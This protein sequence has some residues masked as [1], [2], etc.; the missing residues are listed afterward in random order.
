MGISVS[1]EKLFVS[2]TKTEVRTSADEISLLS[3]NGAKMYM[4][5]GKINNAHG[6]VLQGNDHNAAH[7]KHSNVFVRG[8]AFHGMHFILA[9]CL[10]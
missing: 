5:G 3:H 2:L 4:K 10:E 7:I 1:S 9:S 8:N 6:L